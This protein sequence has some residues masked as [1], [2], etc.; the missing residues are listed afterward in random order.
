RVRTP[1]GGRNSCDAG[2]LPGREYRHD[3]GCLPDRRD[4]ASID[5]LRRNDDRNDH[6][7]PGSIIECETT[8][9]DVVLLTSSPSPG[10]PVA[11]RMQ[12]VPRGW[13]GWSCNLLRAIGSKE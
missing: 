10:L 6:V 8:T 1:A 4:S 11:P 13:E 5:E 3:D 12:R 2:L 9:T 7:G